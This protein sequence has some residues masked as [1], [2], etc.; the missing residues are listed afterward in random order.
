[1]VSLFLVPLAILAVSIPDLEDL[2]TLVGAGASSCLAF[3]FPPLVEMLTFGRNRKWLWVFPWPVRMIKDVS[4]MTMGLVGFCFGT[5]AALFSIITTI[6]RSEP[7][8]GCN[9]EESFQT[10]CHLV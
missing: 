2:I 9:L 8:I 5:F 3:I 10:A 4:I 6:G 7:D 1:M